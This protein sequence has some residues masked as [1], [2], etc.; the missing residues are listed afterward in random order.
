MVLPEQ[1]KDIIV[2]GAGAIGMEFALFFNAF[3]TK[4]TVI[5]MLPNV[6]PVEDTEV[7]VALEKSLTKQGLKILAG[8][9]VEKAE[10]TNRGVKLTLLGRGLGD[11]R[12]QHRVGGDWSQ[13]PP[14][15]GRQT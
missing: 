6:L 4:V 1:P 13:S 10:T 12:G 7:N 14:S 3:G 8:T 11:G 9:K 2:I 15:G 5:E